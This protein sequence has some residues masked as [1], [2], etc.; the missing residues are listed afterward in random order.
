VNKDQ[1][2]AISDGPLSGIVVAD[3]SRVLAGPYATM[4]LG[5]M[6]ADVIKVESKLG[7]ETR[8]WKPPSF[9]EDSTYYLGINRNKRS[10]VLDLSDPQDVSVAKE[11]IRRSDV[12]IENFRSGAMAKFGLDYLGAKEINPQIIYASISGFGSDLGASIPGYD[13]MVQA[14][15]GL[16]SLTGDPDSDPMR[17]GF[18]VIDVITGL[19]CALGIVS[20]LFERSKS[21]EGQNLQVSL[22]ASALSG[23]VNQTSAYTVGHVVP[24]RMGN[25]HPSLYPYEPFDA[26]DGKI[27]V[28]IGND[29]QFQR[30]ANAIGLGFLAEDPN[31]ATN[32]ERNRNRGVLREKLNQTLSSKTKSEWFDIFVGVGVP[33]GPINTVDD[34]IAF[35]R[36]VGLNP[37]IN[38]DYNGGEIATVRNPISFSKTPNSYR[39]SPPKLGEDS[40]EIRQWLSS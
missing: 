13:L 10:I 2:G 20:A 35:A 15:S 34:G 1:V 6:G 19:H 28:A 21:S 3:F 12:M 5:D 16:M 29:G 24:N 22:L 25:A 36:S 30:F 7:D 27:V 18:A 26:S 37:T 38:Q 17:A 31:F 33:A 32:E 8:T 11:L 14:I 23:M 9:G 4:L 40:K 39:Y